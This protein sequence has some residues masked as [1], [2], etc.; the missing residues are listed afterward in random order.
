MKYEK[1]WQTTDYGKFS[2][3]PNNRKVSP[4]HVKRIAES[5]H[6]KFLRNPIVVNEKYQIIDGQHRFKACEILKK[7]IF[8]LINRGYGYKEVQILNQNQ[9]DWSFVNFHEYFVGIGSKPYIELDQFMSK[10]T[11][12]LSTALII[13]SD[14]WFGGGGMTARNDF[15]G[16]KWVFKNT[17][18]ANEQLIKY[19]HIRNIW[20]FTQKRAFVM[21]FLK[22]INHKD[23][24]WDRLV[25]ACLKYPHKFLQRSTIEEYQKEFQKIYN[26]HH[27]NKVRLY[28]ARL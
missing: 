17:K 14:T 4:S 26:Y 8:F 28:Q 24:N 21:A 13:C 15:K 20:E 19:N 27:T 10:H 12:S 6:K 9:K 18:K 7:P 16:G 3:M 25:N 23:C 22:T 5:M 2:L 1:I 11:L